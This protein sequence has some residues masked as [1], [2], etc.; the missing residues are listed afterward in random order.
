MWI[1]LLHHVQ[2][3]HTW[4]LGRC[5]HIDADGVDCSSGPPTNENG[6]I[7]PYFEPDEPALEALRKIVLEPRWLRSLA[8]YVRFR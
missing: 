2:N 8:F 5:D 3:E 6:Q 4:I 7:I 1:S